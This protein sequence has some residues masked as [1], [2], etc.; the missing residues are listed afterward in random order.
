LLV[1]FFSEGTNGKNNYGEDPKGTGNE[2]NQIG[3][4]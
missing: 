4:E 3:N 2:I 1:L